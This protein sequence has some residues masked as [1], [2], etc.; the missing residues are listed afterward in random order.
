MHERVLDQTRHGA[1][2]IK[3]LTLNLKV[4]HLKNVVFRPFGEG[5]CLHPRSINDLLI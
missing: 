3:V 2:H 5:Y 4:N 1:F